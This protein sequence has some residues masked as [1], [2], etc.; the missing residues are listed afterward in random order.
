MQNELINSMID[1]FLSQGINQE[2]AIGQMYI[3]LK[4]LKFCDCFLIEFDKKRRAKDFEL[5][6]YSEQLKDPEFK[7]SYKH[8]KHTYNNCL[9]ELN[10]LNNLYSKAEEIIMDII[11]KL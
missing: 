1:L 6:K 4:N 9:R 11:Q 2:I 8:L 7:S 5:R 3:Q 10:K